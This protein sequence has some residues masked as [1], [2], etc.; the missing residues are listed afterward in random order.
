MKLKVSRRT[1]I[2]NII[3]ELSEIENQKKKKTI[4]KVNE[5]KTWFVEKINKID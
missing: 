4:E 1:E 3:A 2:I 5:T